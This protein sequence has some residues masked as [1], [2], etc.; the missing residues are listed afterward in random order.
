MRVGVRLTHFGSDTMAIDESPFPPQPQSSSE[1]LPVVIDPEDGL[2]QAFEQ[3]KAKDPA[4]FLDMLLKA[5]PLSA[6]D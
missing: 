1:P 6:R 2:H 5:F 4:A 3:L